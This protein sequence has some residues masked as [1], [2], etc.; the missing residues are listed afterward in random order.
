MAGFGGMG[1]ID[2]P[3]ADKPVGRASATANPKAV[4]YK[5]SGYFK[6]FPGKKWSF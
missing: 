5:V 2:S 1:F 6:T 4:V 3:E